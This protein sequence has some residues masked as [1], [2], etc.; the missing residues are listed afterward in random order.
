MSMQVPF[1]EFMRLGL[2][3]SGFHHWE[4]NNE[5]SNLERFRGL[6]GMSPKRC[7]QLWNDLQL[8]DDLEGRI[9]SDANPLHL[10]LALRLMRTYSSEI[11]LAGLF[12]LSDKAVRK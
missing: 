4:A 8:N 1:I 5:K 3:I 6:Y 11:V 12:G 2:E 7:E 10:L 9:T